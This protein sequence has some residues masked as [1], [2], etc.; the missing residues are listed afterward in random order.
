MHFGIFALLDKGAEAVNLKSFRFYDRMLPAQDNLSEDGLGNL[1]ALPLQGQALKKGNSAFVDDNWNAYPDQWK[2]LMST[3][4]L[5]QAQI[6]EYIQKWNVPLDMNVSSEDSD[7]IP[8][9]KKPWERNRVFHK[10]DV[11]GRLHIVL[12]N[13]IYIEAINLKPRIQNQIRRLAA[14]YNPTF[15][16]NNAIGLSNYDSPR[17]IYLGEDD[18]GYICIP[19]GLLDSLIEKCTQGDISYEIEDKRS[20]GHEV[21]AEFVGELRDNQKKA[22]TQLLEHDC[23]ILSAATAFGKTVVCSNIISKKRTSTLILLESSALIEQWEKALSSFLNIDL[24]LPEYKTKSGRIKKYKSLIGVIQGA[25]DASTGIIDIAMVGSLCK[26][27]EYHARL[28]EY[29][30]VLVDECH[31]SASDTV[32]A[33]LREV[34]AKYVYG[35][36]ATPFRGD[37]LERINYMLL[38]PVRFQYS[39][40]E[41]AEEQGIDH[42]VIPRF[43]RTVSPQG[44]EKLH[45]NDAYEIIRDNEVRNEQIASDIQK[46]IEI[47]RTPVVLTKYKEHA[48]LLYERVKSCAD[49]V[50]LLTGVKSKKEQHE[51]RTQMN[52][53]KPEETMILVATGQLIGEG[54]DYP[55]LDTLIM[56]TPVAWKGI[57]EQYAG[58]LNRDYEGKQNVMIYDYVDSHIPV[59]NKMYSKRMKAYKRI[60]YKLYTGDNISKQNANAIFDFDTYTPVYE[61]D[62]QE[63]LREIIIS[64]P[65]LARNKVIRMIQILKER[66]EAGVKVTIVTWHPDAYIYGHEGYRL[67]LMEMLRNMGF[68]IELMKENCEHYAVIDN[69]I[70][71]YGSMNL[72]SKEDVEDNIM[73]VVSKEI[74]SELLEMTFK[75]GNNTQKPCQEVFRV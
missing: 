71:W 31:H 47:G 35:V 11:D 65:T 68:H 34:K 8:D 6:E 42:L 50:F 74:A 22:V 24:E 12:S 56:A 38:G 67:E 4:R 1:I 18:N 5:S 13:L 51:L 15:F 30:L 2:I 46:C 55:R 27:G 45:V 14:F 23:G 64:S 44:C 52:L 28:Q 25:K 69:E 7:V 48:A 32:S 75:N 49:K 41:K 37:G 58:R 3:D 9:D 61:K 57:V 66:Q 21:P 60:G 62:L 43:T 72:L 54:F 29:G 36:T 33:V 16:K 73:R 17:Y 39:A 59:F 19:R 63:A 53:V 40:K 20:C 26:K 10:D 70:V